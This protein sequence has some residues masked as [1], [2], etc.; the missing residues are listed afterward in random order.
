MTL[1]LR[2]G[3]AVLALIELMLGVWTSLFPESFYRDVP[4]VNLTP[5]YSEHLFRDFGG[6]TL[7]LAIVLGAAAIWPTTRLVV[8]A[9]LAYLAFSAPHF[10]FHLGHL[11][12]ATAV[13]A[14]LLTVALAATVI[15]PF[16]LIGVAT[17]RV[18]RAPGGVSAPRATPEQQ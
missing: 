10:V 1:T 9:L 8:I 3:L 11:H 17:I 18:R 12:G 14:S 5:P 2:I 7:G 6:A 13:E 16:A 4:T 15:L